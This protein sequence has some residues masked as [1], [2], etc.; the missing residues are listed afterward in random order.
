MNGDLRQPHKSKTWEG[1]WTSL[2][3]LLARTEPIPKRCGQIFGKG[4]QPIPL[5]RG[6][7]CGTAQLCEGKFHAELNQAPTV[8]PL[9]LEFQ[10]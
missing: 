5:Q 4:I 8:P 9:I 7:C 3:A 10:I 2:S 6:P 1:A